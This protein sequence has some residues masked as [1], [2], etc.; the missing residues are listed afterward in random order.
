MFLRIISV[1][2]W[3]GWD[4]RQWETERTNISWYSLN[5]QN[6]CCS[7]GTILPNKRCLNKSAPCPHIR[8]NVSAQNMVNLGFRDDIL[9]AKH[10]WLDPHLAS[11]FAC[12][13]WSSPGQESLCIIL[14]REEH[15]PWHNP[16]LYGT[17]VGD[18]V[19]S[20]TFLLLIFQRSSCSR[21]HRPH[22]SSEREKM[23][24][25]CVMWSAPCP[26]LLSGNTKAEMS[27]WKKMVRLKF[28]DHWVPMGV[29][30]SSLR[31]SS[32]NSDLGVS[33]SKA[34]PCLSPPG[35]WLNPVCLGSW[36]V[37]K[38]RQ[39]PADVFSCLFLQAR[40][41]FSHFCLKLRSQKV[42]AKEKGGW[43][44]GL[45]IPKLTDWLWI[46][47]PCFSSSPIYSPVQQLP[48]DQR[49]QENR[50]GHLS[51]WGQDPGS[52]RDQLQGHSGHCEWWDLFFLLSI[53]PALVS[54][55]WCL[56][57]SS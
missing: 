41:T 28:P 14:Y 29:H 33:E 12:H 51:L 54:L 40:S 37:L 23:L 6:Q 57:T 34:I 11:F 31:Y 7:I 52:G 24:W 1:V 19:F 50:W 25:L 15:Y 48:A 32:P 10:C 17:L 42:E 2:G 20:I 18:L 22:R 49:H 38:I 8:G 9:T 39:F 21:M 30:I 56:W 47:L 43:V 3:L 26:Q 46:A 44:T 53:A 27:S 4:I 45:Q 55:Q 36:L 16:K 13:F 5:D 35:L